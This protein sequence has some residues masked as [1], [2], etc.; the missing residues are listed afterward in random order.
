MK[1]RCIVFLV[2]CSLLAGSA[3]YAQ[4]FVDG[5]DYPIGES[6]DEQGNL[7]WIPEGLADEENVI[8][9]DKSGFG[10]NNSR[11]GQSPM[12]SW[13]NSNDVGNFYDARGGLHPGEDWN[14]R[15]EAEREA[16]VGEP[17]LAIA[18]G[19]VEVIN[20]M[21]RQAAGC[22]WKIILRHIIPDPE[23]ENA[24][25]EMYSVYGHVT[26]GNHDDG[27]LAVSTEEFAFQ[28]DSYVERGEQIA[29]I[30]VATGDLH[31]SPHLHLE[32]RTEPF[33]Y[34][35]GTLRTGYYADTPGG[36]LDAMDRDQ[37][38]RAFDS[39][40]EDGILDPS[41]FIESCRPGR[42]CVLFVRG[43]Q[44]AD[45]DFLRIT[46]LNFSVN[47]QAPVV[48]LSRSQNGVRNNLADV[49]IVDS[50]DSI[51]RVR[52]GRQG[53]RSQFE[54]GGMELTVRTTQGDSEELRIPFS[55]VGSEDWD[56]GVAH[57]W[58]RGWVNGKRER[59]YDRNAHVTRA[60]FLKITLEAL[61]Q[62]VENGRDPWY[63]T[64]L[65]AGDAVRNENDGCG[66]GGVC[67]PEEACCSLSFWSVGVR[68]NGMDDPLPREEA[69]RLIYTARRL[70]YVGNEDLGFLDVEEDHA[71][72]R[73]I[74]GCE[75]EGLM[76]GDGDR[77]TF[78]PSEGLSRAEAAV[79]LER[80][81]PAVQVDQRLP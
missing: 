35:H 70:N 3:T 17:V 55:D 39:M 36:F 40:Y 31:P 9:R 43:E 42:P 1:V 29:R 8:F 50:N 4:N 81:F 80:A 73:Y 2:F 74:V 24:T 11:E 5:F 53:G 14:L 47:G 12:G 28:Q 37:V 49:S 61:G 58:I 19:Y 38:G 21:C 33:S 7:R 66:A 30:A 52:V 54:A 41:D 6:R 26:S 77:N 22:G 72:R 13:Y 57:A 46:G 32:L 63:S 44:G 23:N 15:T 59:F 71:F 25:I 75:R 45:A 34:D 62:G 69:A 65:I 76:M 16:D 48:T 68:T 67:G 20:P 60:E 78:R 79:V 18:N 10:P 51:I 27:T 56:R 64:H